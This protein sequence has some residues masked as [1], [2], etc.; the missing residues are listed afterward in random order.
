[1][2]ISS[3]IECL[4]YPQERSKALSKIKLAW[5]LFGAIERKSCNDFM[6]AFAMSKT[7]EL[8]LELPPAPRKQPIRALI[9]ALMGFI[10]YYLVHM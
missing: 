7:R 6:K 1:M 9:S 2:S 3:T 8:L 10:S 4:I 5:I